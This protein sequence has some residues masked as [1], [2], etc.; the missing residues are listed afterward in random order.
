MTATATT[1]GTAEAARG[2]LDSLARCRQIRPFQAGDEDLLC[3]GCGFH[4][5]FAHG[6]WEHDQ[7]EIRAC[8]EAAGEGQ[9]PR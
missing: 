1:P 6:H 9:W 2:H 8:R 3:G 7:A 5:V 4:L